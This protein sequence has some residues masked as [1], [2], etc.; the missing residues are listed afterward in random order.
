MKRG[1]TFSGIA[2]RYKTTVA[3]L[4]KDNGIKER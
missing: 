3:K 1:D 2:K 4:V